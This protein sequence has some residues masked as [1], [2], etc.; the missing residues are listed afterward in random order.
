MI[1]IDLI[2]PVLFLAGLAGLARV[3]LGSWLAPGAFFPLFWTGLCAL[4]LA[5]NEYYPMWAPALW[6]IDLSLLLFYV[7]SLGGKLWIRPAA[8]PPGQSQSLHLHRLEAAV[9]LCS[10]V[11]VL[12]TLFR[13]R[14]APNLLDKPPSW[15]QIFLG[16]LYAAPLFGGILF[17]DQPSPRAKTISL[18]SLVPPLFYALASLGRS[19][20]LL[21]IFFWAASYWGT[22]TYRS[23]GRVS[24]L[25]LQMAALALLFLLVC[26]VVG[27]ILGR[28]RDVAHLPLAERLGSYYEVL[29]QADLG[30]DLEKFRGSVFGHPYS[31]S[32][33]LNRTIDFPPSPRLGAYAFAGPLD[34]LGI[35]ERTPFENFVLDAGVDSNVYTLFRPPVEDFGL[36]GSFVSFLIA[37][38]IA[39]FAYSN[40]AAGDI[41]WLPILTLFY[42]HV[43][44]VGGLFFAYNSFT[45]AQC[46]LGGYL[47]FVA[48][49]RRE[50][51]PR[52]P[53]AAKGRVD[54]QPVLPNRAYRCE[55]QS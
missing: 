21:G 34:L 7:G 31:F 12:Y 45:L 27:T 18:L 22:R 10:V 19:Q 39:G 9:I 42:P 17:A 1:A 37:G 44:V 16:M 13:E 40:I 23:R 53:L 15:Y 50:L 8:Q 5:V 36:I 35:V 24:L 54:A 2:F 41:R 30:R 55:S 47:L 29:E 6:W 14:Y 11:G 48:K 49:R 32:Y 46:L 43:M 38:L 3:T 20:F 4:C 26:Y 33:Y 51:D 52:A 25:N 28:L